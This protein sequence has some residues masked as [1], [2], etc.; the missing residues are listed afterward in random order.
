MLLASADNLLL[1]SMIP[2]EYSK[3]GAS[4]PPVSSEC[5]VTGINC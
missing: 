1:G 4:Y 5:Q 2:I 3:S